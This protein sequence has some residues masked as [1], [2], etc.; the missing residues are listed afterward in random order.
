MSKYDLVA[1]YFI[2]NFNFKFNIYLFMTIRKNEYTNPYQE[3][4]IDQQVSNLAARVACSSHFKKRDTG[5]CAHCRLD[6]VSYV[7]L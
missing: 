7:C 6:L 2:G 3:Y 1:F 4:Q 5:K